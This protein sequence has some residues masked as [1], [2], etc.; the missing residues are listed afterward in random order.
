M[1]REGCS[2]SLSL[3]TPAVCGIFCV[4]SAAAAL[5]AGNDGQM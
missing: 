4:D 3:M 5:A 1:M 2:I